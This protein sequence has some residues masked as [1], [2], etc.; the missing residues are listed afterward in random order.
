MSFSQDDFKKAL[1]LYGSGVTVVTY[2]KDGIASGITV[3]A[4]S[5]VS[6][7]PA[8]VMVCLNQTSNALEAIAETKAFSIHFLNSDQKEISGIFSKNDS[9]RIDFL[10]NSESKGLTGAKHI[11]GSLC[12][13]DCE[14]SAIHPAGDHSLVIGEVKHSHLNENS[15]ILPLLYYNRN[16]RTIKDL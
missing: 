7:N 9:S 10:K 12:I 1:S 15:E 8:L 13:L 3:S 6:L 4:F 5:S 11:I 14:L 2:E 16:Y